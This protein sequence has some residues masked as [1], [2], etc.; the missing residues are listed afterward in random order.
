VASGWQ[1]QER[2]RH[3]QRVEK[4]ALVVLLILFILI[5]HLFCETILIVVIHSK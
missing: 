3:E 4:R 5:A 1:L 2:E